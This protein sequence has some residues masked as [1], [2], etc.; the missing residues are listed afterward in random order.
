MAM[1]LFSIQ[2][3]LHAVNGVACE[4]PSAPHML[5]GSL[6]SVA[7]LPREVDC[8]PVKIKNIVCVEARKQEAAHQLRKC[9]RIELSQQ[10]LGKGR[11]VQ[12]RDSTEGLCHKRCSSVPAC[13]LDY[14]KRDFG[15]GCQIR[16]V[17]A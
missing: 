17:P 7:K 5:N 9:R 6:C 2:E 4:R 14:L 8:P 3:R 13:T 15:I 16:K 1:V 12:L 11:R 10:T